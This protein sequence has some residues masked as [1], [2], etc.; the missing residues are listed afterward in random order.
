MGLIDIVV[1]HQ[2]HVH[3]EGLAVAP[4]GEIDGVAHLEAV[5]DLE[6]IVAGPGGLAAYGGDD[7]PLADA[8]GLS[9]RILGNG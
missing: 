4:D 2:G 5:S 6:D 9:V 8:L 7:V 3:V 1:L